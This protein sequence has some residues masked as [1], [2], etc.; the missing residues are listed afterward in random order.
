MNNDGDFIGVENVDML[1]RQVRDIIR[2]QILPST[3]DL[4]EISSLLQEDKTIILVRVN[5]GN[6]LFYIKKKEKVQQDVFIEME[7]RQSQWVKKK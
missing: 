6:K 3:E 4:C 1:M 2:D 5:K 7:H